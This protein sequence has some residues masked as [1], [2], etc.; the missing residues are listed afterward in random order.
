VKLVVDTS[1]LIAAL[2]RKS[3]VRK[4]FLNPLFE[5]YVPEYCIEEIEGHVDEISKRS[6]LSV[7]SVYL[8]L[9]VLLASVQVVPADR[10]V[11]KYEEAEKIMGKIDRGDVP[12][13]ALALSFP[14]DGIWT[15]DKHFLKQDR[16]KV[17]RTKDL[18]K[19]LM[20]E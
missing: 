18:L 2:M 9:G 11:K 7:E 5:F 6:G 12:F 15:E 14:N 8:L 13:V 16:V 3:T 4:L 17:W 10:I 19:L 20:G 1:V